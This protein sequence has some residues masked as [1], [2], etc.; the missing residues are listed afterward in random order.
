MLANIQKLS[1]QS[2][3]Q[4]TIDISFSYHPNLIKHTLL[5]IPTGAFQLQCP[6]LVQL[7][8]QMQEVTEWSNHPEESKEGVYIIQGDA[9]IGERIDCS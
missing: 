3:K 7:H 4:H 9:L 1:A 2:I 8:S 5:N 6:T